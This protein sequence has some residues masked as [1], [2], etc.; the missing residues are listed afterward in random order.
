MKKFTHAIVTMCAFGAA[1]SVGAQE[2]YVVEDPSIDPTM[3]VCAEGGIYDVFALGDAAMEKLA[4]NSKIK[5][6]DYRV[7]TDETVNAHFPGGNAGWASDDDYAAVPVPADGRCFDGMVVNGGWYQWWSGFYMT[8]KSDTDLT[9]I[10]ENSH[11]HISFYLLSD[12]KV[13]TLTVRWFKHDGNDGEAP[14]I[15]FTDDNVNNIVPVCV[16]ID[17][18]NRASVIIESGM[19]STGALHKAV[20]ALNLENSI[21]IESGLSEL[22]IHIRCNDKIVFVTN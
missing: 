22:G 8:R 4:A 1:L 9:H 17:F 21:F 19:T 15:A 16:L 7:A 6:N 12:V 18:F 20:I 10:N 11:L 2:T 13:P 5:V 14:A 3:A